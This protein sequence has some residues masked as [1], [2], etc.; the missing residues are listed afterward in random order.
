MYNSNNTS[1]DLNQKALRFLPSPEA[2]L[3]TVSSVVTPSVVLPATESTSIQ[4][5]TQEMTT[6]SMVGRYD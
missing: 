1:F 4:K 2:L 6:M 3:E 5:E